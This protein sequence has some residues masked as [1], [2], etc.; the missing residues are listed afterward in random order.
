MQSADFCTLHFYKFYKMKKIIFILLFFLSFISLLAQDDITDSIP[1]IKELDEVIV[2]S[3]TSK[4]VGKQFKTMST[5][6]EYLEKSSKITLIRRGGYA[7]EPLINNMSSER[8]NITID[9]MHIFGACTDKMDPVTSYVDVSNLSE[10]NVSSGQSGASNGPTVGGGLNLIR[11]QHDFCN[12]GWSGALDFGIES[13]SGLV[14]TGINLKYTHSKFFID[15]DFTYRNADNYKAGKNVLVKFSQFTK[16]N[17]SVNLGVKVNEKNSI[18][19]SYIF[20]NAINVGY[21]A[22]PMD[23][24]LARASIA[25]IQHSAFDLNNFIKEWETKVY[26]NTIQH[27]M[28]DTKRPSVPIHMDMPGWST[29]YGLN[30]RM[31]ALKNKHKMSFNLNAYH[32]Q[33]KAEMTMYPNNKEEPLMF[34]YTWPDIR[35]TYVGISVKD[36]VQL[37]ENHNIQYALSAGYHQNYVA[38]EFG[39]NSLKIFYPNMQASKKRGL[40]STQIGYT[41]N[42]RNF[43]LNTGFAYGERAPSVS[44]AYG[45]YLFNSFDKYDYIGNPNLKN[46]QSIESDL[47]LTYKISRFKANVSATYFHILDYIIGKHNP[48]YT[49]MT[50]GATGVREYSA[51]KSVNILTTDLS[52]EYRPINALKTRAFFSYSYGKDHQKQQLPLIRPFSFNMGITYLIKSVDLELA[53]DGASKQYTYSKQ[54]GESETPAFAILNFYGGYV[55]EK[56]NYKLQLRFGVEN[57]LNTYYSTYSDWNHIPRKGRNF[58]IS[59]S[60]QFKKSKKEISEPEDHLG[61]IH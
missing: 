20:D 51:L 21:P 34:M 22:L 42:K 41:F 15:A 45:F 38:N 23:V 13:N 27:V 29:T 3:K 28:D 5:L 61:H 25:N 30:S 11:T 43:E 12:P 2:L 17:T 52:L 26:F 44:E 47:G 46:E 33:S 50:I 56:P 40:Y 57:I 35:T 7:W 16:Y 60:Y 9:G 6:D 39:L 48:K 24:S 32:N 59:I 4:N 58:F 36:R 55:L 31:E 37:T 49:P 19:A 10:I 53:I 8:L 1:E 54:Y 14:S 18:S